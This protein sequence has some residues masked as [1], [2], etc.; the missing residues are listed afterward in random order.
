MTGS[1]CAA[2][3]NW[4]AASIVLIPAISNTFSGQGKKVFDLLRIYCSIFS[5]ISV[6]GLADFLFEVGRIMQGRLQER[7]AWRQ[8]DPEGKT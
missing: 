4:H 7:P 6:R 2:Q 3:G 5:G 1:A 8:S